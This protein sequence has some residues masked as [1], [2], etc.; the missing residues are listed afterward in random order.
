MYNP[1]LD[2]LRSDGS[3]VVNKKLAHSIGLHEAII[4]SELISK[5]C[6]FAERGQLENGYFYN[7]SENLFADTT[8]SAK[9]QRSAINNLESLG[10][11]KT[12]IR[13]VPA[14]KYFKIIQ[15]MRLITNVVLEGKENQQFGKKVTTSLAEKVQQAEQKGNGNNT[16]IILKNNN[17]EY[18]VLTQDADS[19]IS[20]YLSVYYDCKEDKHPTLTTD[21]YDLLMDWLTEVKEYYDYDEWCDAVDEHFKRLPKSNNGSIVAFSEASFRYFELLN[22]KQRINY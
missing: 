5:F 22:P 1:I 2:F 11:I 6:Y 9:Q 19:F 4:Y 15:D 17:K 14:K 20:Y 8:L 16:N 10:L 18:I 3:I 13:G 12:Q 21:N 7:V